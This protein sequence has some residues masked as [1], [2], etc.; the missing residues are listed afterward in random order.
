MFEV[1]ACNFDTV[2]IY[3]FIYPHR[4]L[5]Y[6]FNVLHIVWGA[7]FLKLWL[8][9]LILVYI[10]F[11]I[12]PHHLNVKW[13]NSRQKISAGAWSTLYYGPFFGRGRRWHSIH[14]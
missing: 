1:V 6:V 10:Y 3:F 5:V 14:P 13:T 8:V 12:Y 2:H 7:V 4:G 11:F 9:T